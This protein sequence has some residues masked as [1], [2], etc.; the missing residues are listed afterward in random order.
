MFILARKVATALITGCSIVLKPSQQTPN[1]AA[2][3]T[4]IIAHMKE[5]PAGVYNFI[6]GTG[7]TIGT[8]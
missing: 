4:K 1:T 6:T 7:S 8:A 5:L 3:F 2:E